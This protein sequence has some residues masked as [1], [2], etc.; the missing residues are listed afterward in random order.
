M[1]SGMTKSQFDEWLGQSFE[2]VKVQ[3]SCVLPQ[4]EFDEFVAGMEDTG[5]Q[6]KSRETKVRIDRNAAMGDVGMA[7]EKTT[8]NRRN[9]R[10]STSKLHSPAEAA[11]RRHRG[12]PA[13]PSGSSP[14]ASSSSG[15][16]SSTPRAD[17]FA[18]LNEGPKTKEGPHH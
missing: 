13:M 10:E 5:G 1:E 6:L 7:L 15:V 17:V 8:G 9:S 2:P 18:R 12:P 3:A 14:S 16:S 4:S 11:K